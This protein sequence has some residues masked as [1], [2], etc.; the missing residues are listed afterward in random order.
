MKRTITVC[1]LVLI[2]AY[3][4]S[5]KENYLSGYIVKNYFDTTRGFINDQRWKST[6]EHISFKTD[7]ARQPI[8]RLRILHRSLFPEDCMNPLWLIWKLVRTIPKSSPPI[9]TS[10]QNSERFSLTRWYREK[11]VYTCFSPGKANEIFIS[12][13]TESISYCYTNRTSQMKVQKK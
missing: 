5:Q 11:K 12:S 13:S 2:T 4:F 1:V 6:P 3:A 10:S 7:A 8:I 9:P